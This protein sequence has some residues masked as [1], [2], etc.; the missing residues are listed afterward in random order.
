VVG[1]LDQREPDVGPGDVVE[2]ARGGRGRHLAVGGALEHPDGHGQ[3]Q[4]RA[5]DEV[6]APVLDEP[7]VIG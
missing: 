5:Q 1:V 7:R 3:L 4:G 6:V 2:E